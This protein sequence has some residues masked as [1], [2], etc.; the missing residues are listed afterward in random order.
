MEN[1]EYVVDL[2]TTVRVQVR[3]VHAASAQEA[4]RIAAESV[5]FHQVLDHRIELPSASGIEVTEMEWTGDHPLYARI[6]SQRAPSEDDSMEGEIWLDAEGRDMLSCDSMSVE[7]K[8]RGYDRAERFI[9]ELLDATESFELIADR[10]GIDALSQIIYLHNSILKDSYIEFFP[11]DARVAASVG[12]V[13]ESLPSAAEWKK[14]VTIHS[15]LS[16]V[17][18]M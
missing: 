17:P 4:Q 14:Y 12:E 18:T 16:C 7:E 10:H 8:L 15:D 2:V 5:N 13:I 3:G 9:K 1:K 6:E 11:E